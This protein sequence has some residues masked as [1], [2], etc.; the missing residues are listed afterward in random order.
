M[1]RRWQ[2][3][4]GAI[5]L[6]IILWIVGVPAFVPIVIIVA[7]IAVPVVGWYMLDSNQRAR[8]RRMRERKQL[9]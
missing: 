1:S 7:A 9:P 2:L 6:A 8:I 5:V 4:A 3:A